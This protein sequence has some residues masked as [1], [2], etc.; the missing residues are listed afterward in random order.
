M[1]MNFFKWLS[2]IENVW[3]EWTQINPTKILILS[4]ILTSKIWPMYVL[5]FLNEC[6]L[7]YLRVE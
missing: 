3:I 6:V 7:L 2:I 5:L 4:N 1:V